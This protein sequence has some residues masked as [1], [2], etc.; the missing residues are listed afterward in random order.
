MARKARAHARALALGAGVPHAGGGA[1]RREVAL[2]VRG[3]AGVRVRGVEVAGVE[4]RVGAVVVLGAGGGGGGG[5]EVGEAA[6]GVGDGRE[7]GGAAEAG[8][9]DCGGRRGGGG[10]AERG[11]A[12]VGGGGE[13]RGGR[14]AGGGDGGG[15]FGAAVHLLDELLP[16]HLEGAARAL[17]LLGL[18]EAVARAQ[19]QLLAEVVEG[20]DLLARSLERFLVAALNPHADQDGEF[21]RLV[22]K[23][24]E[25]REAF[26]AGG[27]QAAE[28]GDGCG[29]GGRDAGG[30]ALGADAADCVD[31]DFEFLAVSG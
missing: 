5:S 24:R 8:G 16:F 17:R 15:Y 28:Y 13:G 14:G 7:G 4:G 27:G 10:G 25:A 29:V 6:A 21:A 12:A 19:A 22:D 2:G 26:A 30:V 31:E 3:G 20:A 23:V 11:G 1:R 18:V 9:G